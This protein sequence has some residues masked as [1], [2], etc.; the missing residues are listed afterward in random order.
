M[1][2]WTLL[3]LFF[4]CFTLVT[5]PKRSLSL[6]NNHFTEMMRWMSN[7]SSVNFIRAEMGAELPVVDLGTGRTV[8]AVSLRAN[9]PVP[10]RYL[11]LSKYFL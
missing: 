7:F 8:L 6:Q 4:F 11:Q 10:I 3:F 9:G 2:C 5:G 1:T